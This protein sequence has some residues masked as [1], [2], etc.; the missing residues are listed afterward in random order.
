M[1]TEAAGQKIMCT[2][3]LMMNVGLNVIVGL[4]CGYAVHMYCAPTHPMIEAT[5][6]CGY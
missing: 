2:L 5:H 6:H 1:S 4:W 3:S